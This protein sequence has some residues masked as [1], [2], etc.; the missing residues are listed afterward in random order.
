M[1]IVSD[2]PLLSG[3]GKQLFIHPPSIKLFMIFKMTVS[4]KFAEVEETKLTFLV[5]I[6]MLCLTAHHR[7]IQV[8]GDF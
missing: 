7:I 3:K 2:L 5:L 4:P 1:H 6:Q 8:A